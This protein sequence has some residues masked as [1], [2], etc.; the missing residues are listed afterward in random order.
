MA[1]IFQAGLIDEPRHEV[2]QDPHLGVEFDYYFMGQ[3][4]LERPKSRFINLLTCT[5]IYDNRGK[6]FYR[7]EA[8]SLERQR[9]KDHITERIK[10]HLKDM[11]V[12]PVMIRGLMRDFE[13]DVKKCKPY[14][15]TN[16]DP[17]FQRGI[18]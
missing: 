3:R 6:C 9:V 17:L 4:D 1:V 5:M 10:K 14:D 12:D 2:I 15:L 8:K 7:K 18:Y 11:G 13:V 16:F